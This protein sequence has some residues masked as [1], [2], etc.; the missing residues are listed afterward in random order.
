MMIRILK[1]STSLFIFSL[2]AQI[3]VNYSVN[4][5]FERSPISPLIYGTNGQ[6]NDF[7]LN[8]GSRRLGGNRVTGYNWEN[9]A[10][11]AG[12]DFQH[13]NDNWLV[14]SSNIPS[15]FNNTPGVVLT[16][17]HDTSLKM[18]AATYLTLPMAGFVSRD[19]GGAV[20][21]AQSAPSVRWDQVVNN[22]NADFSLVP[23]LDDGKVFVD[24]CLNFLIERYGNSTAD[25]G[26]RGYA[27]DNE[28]DLWTST[29]PRL[30]TQKP[31]I[32]NFLNRS[33]ALARTIKRMDR[34]AEVIG[35][36]SFGWGGFESFSSASD[37]SQYRAMRYG[38]FI[39][40][41]LGEMKKRSDSSRTRLVDMI[42]LHWYPEATGFSHTSGA[43]ERVYN[44]A[45][46]TDSGVAKAR[47]QSTRSLYD[48][49]FRENS[50]ITNF[51]QGA[52]INLLGRVRNSIN[53]FYP[54]TKIAFTEYNFGG[55]N[56]ISGGIAQ[57]DVLGIFGKQG[58]H[59]A[60]CWDPVVG[61]TRS[62]FQ[63]FRNYDGNFST[64]GD[65]AVA[66]S[67]SDIENST[68]YASV[69]E[70]DSTTH[71]IITNKN[72]TKSIRANIN[73]RSLANPL[74]AKAWYFD[75][76]GIA[77]KPMEGDIELDGS[78]ISL[79]L[80]KLSATHIVI[81]NNNTTILDGVTRE[82]L[83]NPFVVYPNPAK[84]TLGVGYNIGENV[85]AYITIFDSK[86][87][88]CFESE[89][90]SGF[91]KLD[92]SQQVKALASGIYFITLKY[93]SGRAITE[94]I[95]IE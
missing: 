52:A 67:S 49:S 7:D 35:L 53:R 71:L 93:A 57:V 31:T 50:W 25:S 33:A 2:Q 68:I 24:E 41:Y 43:Q 83:K 10:S 45:N 38:W 55:R 65:T 64:F 12:N 32:T 6:S 23:D 69:N 42:S 62:A 39:D 14:T 77:L 94:K 34:N 61:F 56:H 92:L 3:Q 86:G 37:W 84:E 16:A 76:A 21:T 17:F 78:Q 81:K 59:L 95:F 58:V 30:V 51:G 89:P 22:K 47:M 29:H 72:L 26:I 5:T 9:N 15:Q 91:A 54:G 28:P 70:K 36:V 13:V 88:L 27:L 8:L 1:I 4:T 60:N 11:N 46:P 48:P 18:N 73:I 44:S 79:T 87:N 74:S 19:K 75:D 85:Q 80:P 66:A 63:I 40:A 20:T 82:L 90:I